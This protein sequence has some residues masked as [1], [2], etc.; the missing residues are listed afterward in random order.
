MGK[1][2]YV[3]DDVRFGFEADYLRDSGWLIVKVETPEQERV[4]RAKAQT[5]KAPTYA[6]LNHESEQEIEEIVQDVW[7]SGNA[8]L[9]YLPD[10]AKYLAGDYAGK[11]ILNTR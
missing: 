11:K 3:C 5:G 9:E 1:E 6:E 10:T 4:R 8:P 7:I 2:P